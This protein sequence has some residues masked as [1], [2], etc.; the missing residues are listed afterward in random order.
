MIHLMAVIMFV[1]DV[2]KYKFYQSVQE[3]MNHNLSS[4]PV[5]FTI[6]SIIGSKQNNISSNYDFS[7][8]L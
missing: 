8:T 6:W 4:G 2:H 3:S 7:W 5:Q 1:N